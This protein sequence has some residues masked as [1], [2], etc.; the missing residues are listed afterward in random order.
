MKLFLWALISLALGLALHPTPLSPDI[1]F[2]FSA[3]LG[4]LF[5]FSFFSVSIFSWGAI[6]QWFLKLRAPHFLSSLALGSVWASIISM[7]LTHLGLYSP[8]LR[9]LYIVLLLLGPSIRLLKFGEFKL[10]TF[11]FKS[12]TKKPE[13]ILYLP[14]LL[15][16]LTGAIIASQ[17]AVGGSDEFRYHLTGPKLWFDFGGFYLPGNIPLVLQCTNWEYLYHWGFVLLAGKGALGLIEAQIFAQWSHFFVGALGAAGT[18]Y[19]IICLFSRSRAFSILT[20]ILAI[21]WSPMASVSY[22]AKNDWG[23]AFWTLFGFYLLLIHRF[24]KLNATAALIAGAF[25]GLGFTSKFTVAFPIAIAITVFALHNRKRFLPTVLVMLGFVIF[26]LPILIRNWVYIGNP[27]YPAL[28]SLFESPWMGPTWVWYQNQYEASDLLGNILKW[29]EYFSTLVK[30]FPVV[31]L[32][33]FFVFFRRHQRSK[34]IIVL[35]IV[36]LLG[37]TLYMLKAKPGFNTYDHYLRVSNVSMILMLATST[38][39]L[40]LLLNSLRRELRSLLFG[41]MVAIAFINIKIDW[42]IW[43]YALEPLS[44]DKAITRL[45][46]GGDTLA[47]IRNH[48]PPDQLIVTSGFNQVYYI[49]HLNFSIV[50]EQPLLDQQTALELDPKSILRTLRTHDARFLLDVQHWTK[51]NWNPIAYRIKTLAFEH[52]SS[53]IFTGRDAIVI[54]LVKLEELSLQSCVKPTEP[55]IKNNLEAGTPGLKI[56]LTHHEAGS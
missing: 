38:L 13:F 30:R 25:L 15:L 21:A 42:S 52:T 56:N 40:E 8:N 11:S 31:L 51:R 12:I 10:K 44:H 47:W 26:S 34:N 28:G 55:L 53:I 17:P 36:G 48:V 1:H 45:L 16:I 23:A 43:K 18:L 2:P 41:A 5:Y 35:A 32:F 33:P 54:D 29:P 46:M 20:L 4:S 19:A 49:S 7:M 50:P 22:T 27:V 3:L 24:K 14:I 39:S 6:L 37:L 9:P